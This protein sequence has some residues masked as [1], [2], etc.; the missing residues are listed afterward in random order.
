MVVCAGSQ[1]GH[2][3]EKGKTISE[4]RRGPKGAMSLYLY[5]ILII[6]IE[7]V[8]VSVFLQ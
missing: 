1:G 7:P 4:P 6:I 8:L 5:N 3:G 2:L